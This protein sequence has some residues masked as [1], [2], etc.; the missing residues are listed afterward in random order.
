MTFRSTTLK[1]LTLRRACRTRR[2]SSY[3]KTGGNRDAWPIKRGQTATLARIKGPGC[4]THIWFTV[5]CSDKLY[6]RRTVLRIYWDGQKSPS[7]EVPLGD[8]FGMGHG[9]A[10]SYQCVPFNT[11]ANPGCEKE[12]GG[13]VAMNCYWQMPFLKEARIEITNECEQDIGSFYFYIDYEEYDTLPD[14]VLYFHAQWRRE[15]PTR[16]TKG[17]LGKDGKNYWEFM[18]EPNLDGKENYVILDAV[19]AGHY[20][21]CSM[22]IDNIDPMHNGQLTWWGEGDDMI[23][24]DGEVWPPS[25]HGTGS[26][27]YLTHA[28]GM[29]DRAGMYAGCN[30]FEQDS[31]HPWRHKLC[32]Y[33]YHIE[34]PVV[35]HKRIR[36]TI[37]HGHANLQN[38]DWASTAY[39]YQTLPA[40]RFPK[41]P[42]NRD[43]R[44]DPKPLNTR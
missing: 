8:F 31:K 29:Q 1:E 41:L 32:V 33:R 6:L 21:G 19:G 18:N 22:A 36:V 10:C 14:D 40:K 35:F 7:V 2:A 25:L 37:E 34:D 28:W 39:W 15:N 43:P 30:L 4:I 13:N 3:D 23:F 16:G 20:V 42:A 27:D 26:E 24:I 5:S 11:S 38:T 17:W 44:P 9:I 12:Y